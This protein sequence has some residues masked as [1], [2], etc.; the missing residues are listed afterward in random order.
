MSLY[1][2]PKYNK[3]FPNINQELLNLQGELEDKEAKITLAKF[4]RANL[5]YTVEL[6]SGFRPALFQEIL[7]KAFFNR[8]FSMMVAARG[9][10][11]STLASVLSFLIPIFEPATNVLIAAPTFRGSRHIFNELQR[12]TKSREAI[13]LRQCFSSD[14]SKRNDEFF[15]ELHGSIIRSVPLSGDRIRGFRAQVLILDEFLL[16]SEDIIKN[17]LMP[18]LVVPSNIKERMIKVEEEDREIKEGKMKEENR[19]IFLNKSRM[20]ALSSAS[21]TFENL[22]KVYCEW[23]ENIYSEEQVKDATYFVSNISWE[24]LP[25]YMVEKSVIE[26]AKSGGDS[27][28]SFLREYCAIFSDGSDS[29]F[30]AKKMYDLTIKE[31]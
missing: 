8:N 15:W 25:S 1:C 14:P 30:S 22:Y 7:L 24:A 29:Y 18:F 23:I 3:I 17:I 13:L 12:I 6:I 16:L 2:P 10:S 26:E 11:K 4:L 27:S 20:I 21:Y 9:A 5:G 19:T 28:A 31:K